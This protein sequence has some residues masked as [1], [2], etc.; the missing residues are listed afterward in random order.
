MEWKCDFYIIIYVRT[1]TD[2][3]GSS[4]KLARLHDAPDRPCTRTEPIRISLT[5]SHYADSD[6]LRES[7]L[8][9][10]AR[11]LP[12][13]AA[14]DWL[15]SVFASQRSPRPIREIMLKLLLISQCTRAGILARHSVRSFERLGPLSI[16]TT[17][18][19]PAVEVSHAVYHVMVCPWDRLWGRETGGPHPNLSKPAKINMV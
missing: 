17:D 18:R 15:T 16:A 10:S 14:S 9:G 5:F 1:C 3:L 6:I 7:L 11:L 8:T 19:I 2:D 4:G 12:R 13:T